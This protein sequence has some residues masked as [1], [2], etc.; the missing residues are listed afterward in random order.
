M[1]APEDVRLGRS[2]AFTPLIPALD[3]DV[4]QVL[5]DSQRK[6]ETYKQDYHLEAV[7]EISLFFSKCLVLISIKKKHLQ[8]LG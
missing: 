4:I 7:S 3:P 5:Q 8:S 6:R 2:S 1:P